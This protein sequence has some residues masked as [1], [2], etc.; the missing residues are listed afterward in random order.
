MHMQCIFEQGYRVG[1]LYLASTPV[2]SPVAVCTFEMQEDTY[3]QA[4]LRRSVFDLAAPTSS[5]RLLKHTIA[6]ALHTETC[7]PSSLGSPQKTHEI[8]GNM[9][10]TDEPKKASI[11][12]GNEYPVGWQLHAITAG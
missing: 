2:R 7:T 10:V 12:E 9:S 11:R 8:V 3:S 1:L 5:L 6:M 4:T